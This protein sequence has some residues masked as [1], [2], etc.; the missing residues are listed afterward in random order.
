MPEHAFPRAE[1][2]LPI[3]FHFKDAKSDRDPPPET[4]YDPRDTTLYPV[5]GGQRQGR[6]ASPLILRPLALA[7]GQAVPAILLLR[8]PLPEGV[9][10]TASGG[11]GPE[12][13]LGRWE[14]TA[15]RDP[16]LAGYRNSPLQGS[17]HGSAQQAFLARAAEKGYAEVTR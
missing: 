14:A 17:P 11:T 1:L 10:L 12:T 2:G 7:N 4:R 8:A 3:V 15:V 9:E 13:S 16:R 5:V 6:M